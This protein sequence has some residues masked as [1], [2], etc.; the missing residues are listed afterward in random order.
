M[1]KEIIFS[2]ETIVEILISLRCFWNA[3]HLPF[4]L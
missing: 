4:I 3:Y 2:V 1:F